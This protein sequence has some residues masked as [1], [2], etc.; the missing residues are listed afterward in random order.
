MSAFTG[1]FRSMAEAVGEGR[2]PYESHDF[3]LNEED[4]LDPDAMEIIGMITEQDK[5]NKERYLQQENDEL[6]RE[7]SV[8]RERLGESSDDWE[9]YPND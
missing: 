3:C 8:L 1:D 7:I 2:L 6:R 5:L 4:Y 9:D